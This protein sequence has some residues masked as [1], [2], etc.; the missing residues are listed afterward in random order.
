MSRVGWQ[1]NSYFIQTQNVFTNRQNQQIIKKYIQGKCITFP[2]AQ[3]QIKA[4][5]GIDAYQIQS[6]YKFD[7]NQTSPRLDPG[8][9]QN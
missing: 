3:K 1:K 2:E 9:L 6:Y 8:Q 4:S 7:Q 5:L